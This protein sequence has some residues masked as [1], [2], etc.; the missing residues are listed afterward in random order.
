MDCALVSWNVLRVFTEC[1]R[2][3]NT[4]GH[5]MQHKMVDMVITG[6]D[7][8][9]RSGQDLGSGVPGPGSRVPG[10]GSGAE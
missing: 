2:A 1:G 4:G 5:L 10:P 6:A 9:L 3:D 7:R 8:V